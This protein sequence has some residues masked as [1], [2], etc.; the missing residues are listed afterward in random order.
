MS[1]ISEVGKVYRVTGKDVNIFVDN[2]GSE[3]AFVFL[4]DKSELLDKA[5]SGARELLCVNYDITGNS[6]YRISVFENQK[7]SPKKYELFEN[8][9]TKV[10][11]YFDSLDEI[12]VYLKKSKKRGRYD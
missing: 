1:E 4:G 5:P 11:G 7:Y 12:F 8:K 3:Q 2:D 6:R 10:A 9:T